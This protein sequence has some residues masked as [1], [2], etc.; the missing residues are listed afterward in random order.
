VKV[1]DIGPTTF[2]WGFLCQK[3]PAT[4]YSLLA[5]PRSGPTL[6][7]RRKYHSPKLGFSKNWEKKYEGSE[8]RAGITPTTGKDGDWVVSASSGV[9]GPRKHP[10]PRLYCC[11][12]CLYFT[13]SRAHES[14]KRRSG[15][16]NECKC[17]VKKGLSLLLLLSS[18][19]LFRRLVD[20]SE[21][22]SP[23]KGEQKNH[24]RAF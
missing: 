17:T 14:F 12:T 16:E 21:K 23:K 1:D 19:S 15:G 7:R 24:I 4:Y 18:S 2:F 11:I 13:V 6:V 9:Y 22:H 10:G 5:I 20:F 3:T 8:V